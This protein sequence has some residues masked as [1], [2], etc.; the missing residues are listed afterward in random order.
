M[1]YEVRI[2]GVKSSKLEGCVKRTSTFVCLHTN[3][4]P[5]VSYVKTILC[6]PARMVHPVHYQHVSYVNFIHIGSAQPLF[7]C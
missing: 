3:H 7:F 6:K 2:L 1:E 4:N 5:M